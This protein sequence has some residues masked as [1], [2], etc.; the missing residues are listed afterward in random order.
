MQRRKIKIMTHTRRKSRDRADLG[1]VSNGQRR[2]YLFVYGTLKRREKFH[3]LLAQNQH[4]HFLGHAK[5]R[6]ELYVL[7]GR[8]F[9]G[10]VPTGRPNRFVHG[11]LFRLR[12]PARTLPILDELEESDS[13]LFQRR[14]V[15]V[16]AQG[17]KMKA[18]TYFY[19]RH[20]KQATLIPTGVYTSA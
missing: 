18:W 17:R 11:Q 15:D 10:A 7:R 2:A 6:G 19:G 5:I 1:R 14:L 20:L 16:W 13:G 9:P 8:D 3:R 12:N 4:V